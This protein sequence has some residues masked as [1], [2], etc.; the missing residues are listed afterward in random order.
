MH[1]IP[2]ELLSPRLKLQSAVAVH[3]SEPASYTHT[4]AGQEEATPA[5]WVQSASA[6]QDSGTA[7]LSATGAVYVQPVPQEF[8]SPAAKLQSVSPTQGGHLPTQST[9]TTLQSEPL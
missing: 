2:Q 4:F 9:S 3:E 6:L 1:P 7:A 5:V 8:E